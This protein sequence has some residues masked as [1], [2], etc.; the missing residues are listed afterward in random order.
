MFMY[1][2]G[3][4]CSWGKNQGEFFMNKKCKSFYN[5]YFYTW[6]LKSLK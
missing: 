4:V 2:G 5:Y 6:N 1:Y 3:V